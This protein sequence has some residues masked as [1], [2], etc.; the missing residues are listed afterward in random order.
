[1]SFAALCATAYVPGGWSHAHS[2]KE[3]SVR[4]FRRRNQWNRHLESLGWL[5]G[6]FGEA[7]L[8]TL[9]T[10]LARTLST[11]EIGFGEALSLLEA[12]SVVENRTFGDQSDQQGRTSCGSAGHLRQR[13][14]AACAAGLNSYEYAF[15]RQ[16]KGNTTLMAAARAAGEITAGNFSRAA[17]AK[18]AAVHKLRMPAAT[19]HLV[20]ADYLEGLPFRDAAFDLIFS[21]N[22]IP[23]MARPESNLAGLLD[24]VLRALNVEGS[25]VLMLADA[26]QTHHFNPPFVQ[27][28]PIAALAGRPNATAVPYLVQHP[29]WVYDVITARHS[30]IKGLSKGQLPLELV[31]GAIETAAASCTMDECACAEGDP[32]PTARRAHS[33]SRRCRRCALA[34]LY[35]TVNLEVLDQDHWKHA[36]V[37][38]IGL[39]MHSFD[40]AGGESAPRAEGP[41]IN[42]SD[43]ECL[44][45][46]R[47][48]SLVGDLLKV[49]EDGTDFEMRR[50]PAAASDRVISALT[51]QNKES[52]SEPFEKF[53]S[54]TRL[55]FRNSSVWSGLRV[56]GPSVRTLQKL[57]VCKELPAQLAATCQ[58]SL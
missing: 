19:P 24:E 29:T 47:S 18:M 38:Y 40:V 55:W 57:E 51:L 39:Y 49:F 15:Q 7:P 56:L 44:E 23:K 31:V 46:A 35:S 6:S 14:R 50:E 4:D 33:T 37:G 53:V 54:S 28:V 10:L 2:H 58:N 41:S 17:L 34:Y 8:P 22:A 20:W 30:H 1:M 48:S 27:A 21:Q 32:R 43:E 42:L 5:L 52:N 36:G 26:K 9:E 13:R 12:L 11:L 45:G 16:Y 3:L 25:A